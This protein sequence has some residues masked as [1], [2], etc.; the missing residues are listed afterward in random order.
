MAEFPSVF[1]GKVKVMD[2]EVFHIEL[3]N[4]AKPFCVHT[5][6]KI[7]FAYREKL[8]DELTLLQKQG[9]IAPVTAP[10]EGAH[11]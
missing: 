10:T 5:P 2:G 4:D 11:L 9:V 1:D 8:Q 3:V 6:R 7:P